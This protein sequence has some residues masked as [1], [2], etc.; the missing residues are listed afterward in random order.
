MATPQITDGSTTVQFIDLSGNIPT[1]GQQVQVIT[2]FGVAGAAARKLGVRGVEG[3]LRGV[4]DYAS[5]AA[6]VAG[7]AAIK[8]L[9]SKETTITDIHGNTYSN[10]L[11]VAAE[12]SKPVQVKTPVGGIGGGA[13]LVYS[14][15]AIQPLGS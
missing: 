13:W 6:A 4:S 2:R 9:Q 10:Y 8:A 5:N 7:I 15:W 14:A 3:R 12:H 1:P 11:V